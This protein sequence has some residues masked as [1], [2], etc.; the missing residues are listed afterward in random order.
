[1]VKMTIAL[2]TFGF[3]YI[4]LSQTVCWVPGSSLSISYPFIHLILTMTLRGV[5]RLLSSPFFSQDNQGAKRLT[6]LRLCSQQMAGAGLELGNLSPESKHLRI[7]CTP[8]TQ[9]CVSA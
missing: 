7:H 6:F 2:G 1:M 9:V 3:S 8:Y 4:Y 5:D